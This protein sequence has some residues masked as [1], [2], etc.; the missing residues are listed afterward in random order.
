MLNSNLQ[1]ILT[2]SLAPL[3]Q[4]I[5][6]LEQ[7][8]RATS[9]TVG[10]G[11]ELNPFR[12]STSIKDVENQLLISKARSARDTVRFL[13]EGI[14]KNPID[15]MR[16][17]SRN[18]MRDC[19]EQ[20]LVCFQNVSHLAEFGADGAVVH[21]VVLPYVRGLLKMLTFIEWVLMV[22]QVAKQ[23][24]HRYIPMFSHMVEDVDLLNML[25]DI[26]DYAQAEADGNIH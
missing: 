16:R 14:E 10:Q 13:E 5:D 21:L 3:A 7:A 4:K 17:R 8:I 6:A 18:A 1:S 24:A 25:A 2:G 22:N 23:G 9:V 19:S 12:Y 11:E 15:T 20:L 26:E